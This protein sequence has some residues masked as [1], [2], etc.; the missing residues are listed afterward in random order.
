[1]DWTKDSWK[2]ET[3]ATPY[4]YVDLDAAHRNIERM[5]AKLAKHGIRH[6]PH[7]KTH[8]SL[9][10]AKLQLAAGAVGITVAKLSEAEA[11]A[12]GGVDD[13]LIAFA[14]IGERNLERLE[15]LHTRI[16]VAVTVDSW[17]AA[18]GLSSVG[19]RANKPVRVLIELDGGLHRGGRQPGN[20]IVD[21][22]LR[23]RELPGI[24]IDGIMAYFGLIYRNGDPEAIAAS[25]EAESETI[26]RVV[27]DLR[28]AGVPVRTVSSGSTPTAKL[29]EHAHGISE[30]RAGN[31]LFNDV[32]A[33]QMGLAEEADCALRVAATV[34][35]MPLPGMATIDAGTKA[36]TSDRSHHGD[37]FGIVVGRP[38]VKIAALNEEHGMLRFDPAKTALAIGDRI[39]IIPNHSCVIPNLNDYVYGVRGDRVVERIRVDAR[40]RN[41]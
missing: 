34:V 12:D 37:G 23:L 20:D 9:R 16:R 33:V 32:S 8:K 10:L 22:A 36:L 21:F 15:K 1:M 4:A 41:Y 39:D 17:E 19:V 38:D 13:I 28:Q 27:S 24:E 6:R 30:V 18:L 26:G 31:Y 25:V 3:P 29:C 5:A 40:G 7:I 11:F 2:N 35:S 14:I